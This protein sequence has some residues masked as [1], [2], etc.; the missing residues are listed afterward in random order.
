MNRNLGNTINAHTNSLG[1]KITVKRIDNCLDCESNTG[2]SDLQSD[3][4]P[5]ELSRLFI[6]A[7]PTLRNAT[8]QIEITRILTTFQL[9]YAKRINAS[10]VN[11]TQGLQIFSL[12]LSQLS[13][14]GIFL[15][16]KQSTYADIVSL[17]FSR[18]NVTSNVHSTKQKLT[19]QSS[20]S[21]A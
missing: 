3:A 20:T 6:A 18:S 4:L 7:I 19:K 10:T 9:I 8:L 15:Y 5:T 12:T 1:T 14:R 16:L 13:Y 21:N 2:P 17:H 11:R